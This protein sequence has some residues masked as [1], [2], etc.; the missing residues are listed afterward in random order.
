MPYLDRYRAGGGAARLTVAVGETIAS[1]CGA[2]RT[3]YTIS[4][5]DTRRNPSAQQKDPNKGL[6]KL[7]LLLQRGQV[8]ID[9][10]N[11]ITLESLLA[12]CANELLKA[13]ELGLEGH[14]HAL[15]N[16][17]G[18]LKAIRQRDR[19]LRGS[20]DLQLVPVV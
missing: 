14:A 9:G 10:P 13:K 18:A 15:Q 12:I 4:G 20:H 1:D 17:E 6:E 11:G 8:G 2:V 19:R 16:V 3:D 7:T 5:Y